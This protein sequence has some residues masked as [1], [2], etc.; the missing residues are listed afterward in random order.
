MKKSRERGVFSRTDKNRFSLSSDHY[1]PENSAKGEKSEYFKRSPINVFE[2][3]DRF[4]SQDKRRS[5]SK[6]NNYSYK[7]SNLWNSTRPNVKKIHNLYK[8][9]KPDKSPDGERTSRNN[10]SSKV[11][12]KEYK[13]LMYKKFSSKDKVYNKINSSS[14]FKYSNKANKDRLFKPNS[15]QNSVEM[16]PSI[17]TRS[18]QFKNILESKDRAS[19]SQVSDLPYQFSQSNFQEVFTKKSKENSGL[20]DR[21]YDADGEMDV[22]DLTVEQPFGGQLGNVLREV[23]HVMERKN[24]VI[25]ELR[26]DNLDLKD[27][28][29]ELENVIRKLLPDG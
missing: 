7:L 27:R 1:T 24:D 13:N 23:K 10:K 6:T 3:F 18:M 21:S 8:S 12:L 20:K 9:L 4:K 22:L 28:V 16:K 29:R 26:K 15:K 14:K 11:F 17:L 5:N 25:R 19:V 2:R